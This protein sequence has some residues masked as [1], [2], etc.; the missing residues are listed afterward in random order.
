MAAAVASGLV[1]VAVHHR[2]AAHEQLAGHA[3]RR[4]GSGRGI[5]HPELAVD[6]GISGGVD[7]L[8]ARGGRRVAGHEGPRLAH[9]PAAHGGAEHVLHPFGDRHRGLH[10]GGQGAEAQGKPPRPAGLRVEQVQPVGLEA[11][12]HGGPLLLG[13]VERAVGIE[14]VHEDLLGADQHRGHGD[15]RVAVDVEQRQVAQVDVVD[16]HAEELGALVRVPDGTMRMHRALRVAGGAGR[17]D[18]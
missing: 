1:P 18:R 7:A 10:P 5:D 14:H 4:L 8:L 15:L 6:H 12:E 16:G 2:V 3:A 9:A 11:V 17:R 13:Q